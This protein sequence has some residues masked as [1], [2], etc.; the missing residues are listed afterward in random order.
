MLVPQHCDCQRAK[1]LAVECADAQ[2][3]PCVGPPTGCACVVIAVV[4]Y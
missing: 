3:C 2:Q 1:R 4:L